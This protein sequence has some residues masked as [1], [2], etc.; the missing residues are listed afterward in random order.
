MVLVWACLLFLTCWVLPKRLAAAIASRRCH[1]A[2]LVVVAALGIVLGV[3]LWATASFLAVLQL[4]TPPAG[5]AWI[6]IAGFF[7]SIVAT[8]IG[9]RQASTALP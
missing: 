6:A 3:F 7:L 9:K 5:L 2:L 1:G 4:G 8:V